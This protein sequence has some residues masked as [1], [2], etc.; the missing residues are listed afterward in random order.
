MRWWIWG[1]S[2]RMTL[3][4]KFRMKQQNWT[5]RM[6]SETAMFE[7]K[8]P[9][10]FPK[11]C[12]PKITHILRDHM[13]Q[14]RMMKSLKKFSLQPLEQQSDWFEQWKSH[15]T[16]G[17]KCMIIQNILTHQPECVML[18]NHLDWQCLANI[19]NQPMHWFNHPKTTISGLPRTTVKLQTQFHDLNQLELTKIKFL[20][21]FHT[22]EEK[23]HANKI[24]SHTRWHEISWKW[25]VLIPFNHSLKAFTLKG[26]SM[27]AT[28]Q[29]FTEI[30][31]SWGGIQWNIQNSENEIIQNINNL[32]ECQEWNNDNIDNHSRWQQ[33]L[34]H[35]TCKEHPWRLQQ[36]LATTMPMT[37]TVKTNKHKAEMATPTASKSV[38][39]E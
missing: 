7:M 31:M 3:E 19:E 8:I 22:I 15:N 13:V 17:I 20:W 39:W 34:M 16:F 1:V 33:N 35:Q 12:Q 26:Q 32:N 38:E 14:S 36:Q 10:H 23:K 25:A 21:T 30:S 6:N 24:E 37:E 5:K 27:E 11:T 4:I 18:K 9:F 29:Q 2:T 28:H